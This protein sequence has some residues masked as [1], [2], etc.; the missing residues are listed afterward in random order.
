MDTF[1][2]VASVQLMQ[3]FAVQAIVA[4]TGDYDEANK[5]GEKAAGMPLE[6]RPHGSVC[7]CWTVQVIPGGRGRCRRPVKE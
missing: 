2:G 1:D 6:G 4:T 5:G 3:R 7:R